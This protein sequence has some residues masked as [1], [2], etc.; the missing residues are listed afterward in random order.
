MIES[1][2]N[3]DI[4][5]ELQRAVEFLPRAAETIQEL[6]KM[7][8][9]PGRPPGRKPKYRLTAEALARAAR[10]QGHKPNWKLI[11]EH[12]DIKPHVAARSAWMRKKVKAQFQASILRA[13]ERE[14]LE[15]RRQNPPL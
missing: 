4:R 15:K 5:K 2:S 8:N 14:A 11:L 3:P 13:L 9:R 10:E 7:Y 1:L 12:P 6:L